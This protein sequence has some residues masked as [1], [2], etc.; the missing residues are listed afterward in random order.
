MEYINM[1]LDDREY[2]LVERLVQ[3]KE[4]ELALKDQEVLLDKYRADISH[5]MDRVQELQE[6]KDRI[7]KLPEYESWVVGFNCGGYHD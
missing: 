3:A 2:R 6:Y 4:K 1:R 7:E 5:L